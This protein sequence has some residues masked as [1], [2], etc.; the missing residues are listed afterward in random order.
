M[1]IRISDFI[2][3]IKTTKDTVRLYEELDLMRPVWIN[4]TRD[5]TDKDQNDFY[6]IKE[7]QSMGLSLKDIQA[8]FEI[9]R[10]DGCG[11]EQLI[12]GVLN[13]LNCELKLISEAEEE[14]NKKRLLIQGLVKDLEELG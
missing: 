2:K 7:M 4:G 9:K 14:L 11:S 10:N 3:Q 12:E 13:S 1:E 6:A 8:I 5:Y